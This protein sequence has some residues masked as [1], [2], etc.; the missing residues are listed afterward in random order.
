MILRKFRVRWAVAL[1]AF[2]SSSISLVARENPAKDHHVI[3]ITVDGGAAFYLHDPKAPIPNL[4]K[5]AAEGV[6]AEGM[7]VS[8]PAVTWPN[9][10]TLVTGVRPAKH[11]VLYNGLMLPDTDGGLRREQEV[12]KSALVAVPTVFDLLHKKG[13]TTAAIN[14]PCTQN[15]DTLDDYFP[16]APNPVR[17]GSAGLMK[18]LVESKI[19]IS[20]NE[21]DFREAG[22]AQRDQVWGAAACYVMETRRPNF[23]LLHFLMADGMQHRFGPQTPEVYEAL[24]LIDQHIGKL[25]ETLGK[26]GLRDST[27][28][29]I[30]ADHGFARFDKQVAA[31][32]ILRKAG[33]LRTEDGKT[34][35]QAI[36][37]GGTLMVYFRSKKTR[38]ADRKKVIELFKN[39]E[40]IGQIIGPDEFSKFGY[41]SP[42]KNPQM[43][44]LVLA[45]ADGYG[46]S[47]LE[48]VNEP[49]IPAREGGAGSHGY[50][51]TNPKMNAMFIAA[52]RGIAQ[53][54]TIGVIE[55][56]DVAPTIAYL[57]GA[58]MPNTDGK[59]LKQILATP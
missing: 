31:S 52:G 36:S 57:L 9:H 4:R 6:S 33:L 1:I 32:A 22:P 27:S 23:L 26:T 11:S 12:D 30:V 56:I 39:Q 24:G 18:G 51:S 49:V 20:T 42:K 38:E 53:H 15:P 8:N 14:W 2:V 50:L 13:F 29:L 41:P 47:G 7:K 58:K 54:K 44:D 21:A 10:T 59:V 17:V 16:D 45:A 19:L 35:V 25:L 28:V 34:R 5:L 40:G 37:E 43:A 3:L 48:M 55:N 46:F